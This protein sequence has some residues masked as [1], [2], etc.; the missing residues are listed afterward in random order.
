MPSVAATADAAIK[1]ASVR[2]NFASTDTF[3]EMIGFGP[4]DIRRI[5]AEESKSRGLSVLEEMNNGADNTETV[6]ISI[7]S[8]K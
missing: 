6:E 2:E 8:I 1:I 7:V 4:A 5:R 3:L